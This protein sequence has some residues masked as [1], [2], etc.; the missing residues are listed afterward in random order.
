MSHPF[1]VALFVS[2]KTPL[3]STT[4]YARV[5]FAIPQGGEAKTIARQAPFPSIL[6]GATSEVALKK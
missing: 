6:S 5:C 4:R 2:V 1:W 3:P